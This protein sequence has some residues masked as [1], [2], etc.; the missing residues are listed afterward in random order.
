[1]QR[2]TAVTV[3]GIL[4]IAKS[5]LG[6]LSIFF[7]IALFSSAA[8]ASNPVFN[9]MLENPV[10]IKLI[11]VTLPIGLIACGVL[12]A[13]GIGLLRLKSWARKVSI[14]YAIYAIVFVLLIIPANFLL[15]FRPML[16]QAR[17]MQG[18]EAAGMIGGAIGGTFS[19]VLGLIYPT[20]LW[21]FMTRPNVIAAFQTPPPLPT[22]AA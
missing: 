21:I 10:Y 22:D 1:M 4:N 8:T 20:L 2:P 3:F 18:P 17:Q 16:E 9:V 5:A 7:S 15:V 14:G 6:T 19:G 11:K 13:A 12:L